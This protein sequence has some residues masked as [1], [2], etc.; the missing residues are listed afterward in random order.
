LLIFYCNIKKICKLTKNILFFKGNLNN[1]N[2]LMESKIDYY[3][4]WN[5]NN[6]NNLYLFLKT[7]KGFSTY[8]FLQFEKLLETK[9]NQKYLFYKNWQK[10]LFF[11]YLLN[12]IPENFNFHQ[13]KLLHIFI[14][15]T[16]FSYQ[17]WRHFFGLP[18]RGQRTWSNNKTIY[19]LPNFLKKF[20]FECFHK[21]FL[22]KSSKNTETILMAEHINKFWYLEWHLEW[23]SANEEFK[24]N[25]GKNKYYKFKID[26]PYLLNFQIKTPWTKRFLKKKKKK[27]AFTVGFDFY[28][29]INLITKKKIKI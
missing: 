27:E 18:I 13:R 19:R 9:L 6:D 23:Q 15:Y 10:I 21:R 8:L 24:Q 22:L 20:I 11:K 5:Y 3:Q 7:L 28:Y 4:Q 25:V 16:V 17:G 29:T 26:Y 14:L 1:K 12:I 2:S